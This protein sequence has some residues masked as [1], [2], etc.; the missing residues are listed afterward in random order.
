MKR[1]RLA[2]LALSV[3]A[4]CDMPE[5]EIGGLPTPTSADRAWWRNLRQVDR[6]RLILD[7][8]SRDLDKYVGVECKP[9]VQRI[10][11]EASRNVASVPL[12]ADGGYGWYWNPGPYLVGMSVNI[13]YVQPGWIVQMRR[14]TATGGIGPHTAIVYARVADGIWWIDSN[15][16]HTSQPNV[17]KM[18]F[19]SFAAFDR[20]VCSTGP[21]TYSVYAIGGG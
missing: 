3:F 9:W 7:R 12:T 4:A 6:D 18:H 15:F 19:E 13:R 5:D 20:A 11:P 8:A 14:T 10:V 17:V 16:Y 2:V 21:C 1:Y